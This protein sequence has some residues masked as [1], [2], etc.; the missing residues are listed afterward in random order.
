MKKNWHKPFP[1]DFKTNQIKMYFS[2]QEN[3]TK[4]SKLCLGTLTE[5]EKLEK[6]QQD[7][8]QDTRT[9]EKMKR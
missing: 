4:L 8:V 7:K 1:N 3:T 9:E 6:N 5:L 2:F